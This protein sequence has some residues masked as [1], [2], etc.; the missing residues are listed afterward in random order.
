MSLFLELIWAHHIDKGKGKCP[1]QVLG[2]TTLTAKS[3]YSINFSRSNRKFCLA[4]IIMDATVFYL[5]MLQ[6][7]INSKQ[8]ILK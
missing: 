1:T 4:C 6:K 3:Q 7:Y 2:D 5:L 8:K